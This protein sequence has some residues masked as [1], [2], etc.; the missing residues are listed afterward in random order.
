[1]EEMDMKKA[2]KL[3]MTRQEKFDYVNNWKKDNY[4][5][6]CEA[7]GLEDGPQFQFLMGTFISPSTFKK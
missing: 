4:T 1:M 2:A 3:S 5:F 7:F 6:L